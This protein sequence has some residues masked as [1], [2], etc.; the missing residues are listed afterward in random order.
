MLSRCLLL[1]WFWYVT[2]D[3]NPVYFPVPAQRYK[4][5]AH[6]FVFKHPINFFPGGIRFSLWGLKLELVSRHHQWNYTS[7]MM[8]NAIVHQIILS[9]FIQLTYMPP[10]KIIFLNLMNIDQRYKQVETNLWYILNIVI[11]TA[12]LTHYPD[13]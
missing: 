13:Q 9:F 7:T 1:Q 5:S 12:L 6:Y 2:L 10:L 4:K 11:H 3:M 8:Q